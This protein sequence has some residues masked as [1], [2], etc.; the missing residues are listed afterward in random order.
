M[1]SIVLCLIVLMGV[2][3]S[4]ASGGYI[5]NKLIASDGQADDHFGRSVSLAS[6]TCVVGAY[7]DDDDAGS[8]Y[9]YRFDG[10]SFSEEAKLLP[11]DDATASRF[12]YSV[13]ID[14]DVCIAGAFEDDDKGDC[15][16]SAYVFFSDGT[17]W[18]YEAKLLASD[19]SSGDSFGSAVSIDQDLCVVGARG[20]DDH[21]YGSGSVYIFR[22]EDPNE[23]VQEA[24][25]VPSDGQAVD[26]FGYSVSVYDQVCIVGAH[27]D[28]ENFENSGSAY[29]YGF[30]GQ[31]WYR[32]A[33]LFSPDQ[34][35]GQWFGYSV[36]MDAGICVVGARD[37]DGQQPGSAYIFRYD[38]PNWVLEQ[39]LISSDSSKGDLFG[40][41]VALDDDVCVVSAPGFNIGDGIGAIYVFRF[42]GQE[43][44]EEQQFLS[45]DPRYQ[46]LFGESV[47]V[48]SG[49][50]LAGN[51]YK[52]SFTGTVYT[53]L[54]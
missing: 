38:D 37:D 39:Q 13:S 51:A 26:F 6:N 7:A 4:S 15:S 12:G 36:D 28:D 34:A 22:F 35:E 49:L 2:I 50:I 41:F 9:V 47:A 25:I 43:W 24:K 19:G 10:E 46:D 5:Q 29:I 53:F 40:F 23:W 52:D 45:P 54:E 18:F 20:D 16:G 44:I 42:D 32:Q 27:L 33:K 8:V 48:D 21:G 17:D 3:A 1:K 11:Y 31:D 30:D 14:S